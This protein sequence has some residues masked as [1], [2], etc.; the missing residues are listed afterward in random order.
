VR[1]LEKA[2]GAG[3]G[4]TYNS[5]T[6][7][8]HYDNS[9]SQYGLLG[10]KAGSRLGAKVRK[11][12]WMNGLRH[13][14]RD[15]MK[16]GTK[17]TRYEYRGVDEDGY[18]AGKRSAGADKAR[19]WAYRFNGNPTGSMTTGGVSSLAI[20]RSELLDEANYDGALS[21]HV[22]QSIRDGIAWLGKNFAVDQ[23]P[24]MPAWHYYYLYG[25]ERAGILAGVHLMERHDWYGEG[26]DYLVKMQQKDGGWTAATSFA[27]R[28][29]GGGRKKASLL[30]E[31]CFALLFLKR[32]TFTVKAKGTPT[33]SEDDDL[34]LT[35]AP[36]LDDASFRPVFDAVFRRFCQAD[37]K[38]RRIL[39]TDFVRLGVRSIPLLLRCMDDE[40]SFVRTSAVA[41][42]RGATGRSYGSPVGEKRS[43]VL[44]DWEQWWVA[45]RSRISADTAAGR[46]VVVEKSAVKPPTSDDD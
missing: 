11:S 45:V 4:F 42:L 12:T 10:L 21:R 28:R 15:Q 17:V 41:A 27:M 22:D 44:A 46:F 9:N 5:P 43:R 39:A 20:C 31:T 38:R 3:G 8:T 40:D 33:E 32:A 36:D 16:H 6:S 29:G 23:N 35:G 37:L 1:L 18:G 30:Q 26:A 25:L 34:D 7:G 14:L 2:Q 13:F 19:G 24:G